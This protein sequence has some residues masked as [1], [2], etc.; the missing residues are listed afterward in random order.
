MRV[1]SF[2]RS[3]TELS[4]SSRVTATSTQTAGQLHGGAYNKLF[5]GL[6]W[7]ASRQWRISTSY[8]P[9]WLDRDGLNGFTQ[10]FYNTFSVGFLIRAEHG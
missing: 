10:I 8:G 6:N 2:R 3:A 4:K 5:F 1:G 9:T 7:W